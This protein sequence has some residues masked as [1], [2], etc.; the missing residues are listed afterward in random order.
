M[1]YGVVIKDE[2]IRFEPGFQVITSTI[3]SQNN[4]VFI[5]KSGN[6]YVTNDEPDNFDI[7]FAEFFVMRHRLYS[8]DEI[9]QIRQA[10]KLNDDRTIH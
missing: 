3:K 10:I 9:L 4:F 8:P 5:T 2:T 6:F 1:V 7:S